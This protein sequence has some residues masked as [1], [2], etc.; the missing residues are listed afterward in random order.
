M[1]KKERYCLSVHLF[2][3]DPENEFLEK[4]VWPFAQ[5]LI[6]TEIADSFFFL[7]SKEKGPHIRLRILG[8][9]NL[10]QQIVRPN[11]EEHFRQYFETRPSSRTEEQQGWFPDNSL[12]FIPYIPD[13]IHFG[14]EVGLPI[15]EAHFGLSSLVTLRQITKESFHSIYKP[16]FHLAIQLQL[17]FVAAMGINTPDAARFFRQL[18]RSGRTHPVDCDTPGPLEQN[19]LLSAQ[20]LKQYSEEKREVFDHFILDTWLQLQIT[21]L[22]DQLDWLLKWRDD[23]KK[24]IR[25]FRKTQLTESELWPIFMALVQLTNNRIGLTFED[26]AMSA[27]L[28]SEVLAGNNQTLE[29]PVSS[30]T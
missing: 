25:A 21:E 22:D 20:K 12:Y 8:E 7:R 16:E 27:F 29:K 24:L 17:G 13:R 18:S 26:H 4:A 6:R 11:L 9:H 2:Y 30:A 23:N 15:A 28:I 19:K 1:A 14:G 3:A 10:L 5:T